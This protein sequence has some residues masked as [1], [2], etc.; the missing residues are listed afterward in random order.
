MN[1][2]KAGD[3]VYYPKVSN[4]VLTLIQHDGYPY[5]LAIELGLRY[6]ELTSDGYHS[7]FDILPSIYHATEENKAKLE[8]FYGIE[9]EEPSV[10]PTSREIIQ[11]K[12]NKSTEPVPCWVSNNPN[13]T[14]PTRKNVWAFIEDVDTDPSSKFPYLDSA[15]KYWLFAT[16]FDPHTNEAITELPEGEYYE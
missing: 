4:K 13:C 14:Q 11:A 7:R 9:L 10:K 8:A 15:E 1:T 16:P 2:F 6:I 5:S 12:L 3:K